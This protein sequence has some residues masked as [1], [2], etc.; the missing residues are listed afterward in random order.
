MRI[1]LKIICRLLR[2]VLGNLP[3]SLLV[4]APMML[5]LTSGIVRLGRAYI[6]LPLRP[7]SPLSFGP[8]IAKSS[9]LHMDTLLT[10]S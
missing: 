1:Q 5:P 7:K 2:G 4:E 9:Y 10:R 6:R 3:F 8:R